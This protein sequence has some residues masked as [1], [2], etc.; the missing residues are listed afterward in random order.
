MTS[1]GLSLICLRGWRG[2]LVHMFY[3]PLTRCSDGSTSRQWEGSCKVS[4]SLGF[5]TYA[6]PLLPHFRVKAGHR[7]CPEWRGLLDITSS[8]K[9]RQSHILERHEWRTGRF[10]THLCNPS[11]PGFPLTTITHNSPVNTLTYSPGQTHSP[12]S[13]TPKTHPI[14]PNFHDPCP[15]VA[16]MNANERPP[17]IVPW[18]W[19]FMVQ[20]PENW[21]AKLSASHKHKLNRCYKA[22]SSQQT[23]P[24]QRSIIRSYTTTTLLHSNSKPTQQLCLVLLCLQ[25][26]EHRFEPHSAPW[27]SF[28]N[29]LFSMLSSTFWDIFQQEMDH[30]CS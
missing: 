5:A 16:G 12:L 4:W 14:G 27:K 28:S 30:V 7:A 29:P 9:K 2:W 20:G 3:L 13:K 6:M 26:K 22:G 19:P 10:C 21:I 8:W 18:M 1:S 11:G 25:R 15:A 24:F 23:L 17:G